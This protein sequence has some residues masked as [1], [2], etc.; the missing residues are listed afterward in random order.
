MSYGL[1]LKRAADVEALIESKLGIKATNK[2]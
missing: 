1:R 2:F